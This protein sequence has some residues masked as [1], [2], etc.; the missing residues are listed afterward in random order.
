LTALFVPP[1]PHPGG[2]P[3][4]QETIA[5]LRAPDG[6]P[7]DREQTHQTLRTNLLEE[8]YETLA[9][10]DAGDEDKLCE[11]L[12]DLLMQIVM[13]G[14]IATE[15][16]TFRLADLI[17]RIDAKLKRRHPHVFG[18]L[19][20]QSTADVLRNWEAIKSEERAEEGLAHR[21]S[22]EGV[23]IALPALARAQELVARAART[24][25]DSPGPEGMPVRIGQEVAELHA[26][27]DP[28]A[29]SHR[30]GDLLFA[31]A[32]VARWLGVDAESALR[33]A[34]DRFTRHYLETEQATPGDLRPDGHNASWER[35]KTHK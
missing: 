6:C 28:T 30:F 22:L 9:A 3:A 13:H 26:I 19:Q 23:P 17:G 27:H 2:L 11:E 14:Q 29:R 10:L 5:R 21:S 7:W 32:N 34:C 25:F 35:A 1:L 33:D 24:G 15:E 8:T 20:V 16:G 18:D 12:G 4:L 31:L